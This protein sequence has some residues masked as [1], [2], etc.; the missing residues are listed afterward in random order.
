MTDLAEVYS[1]PRCNGIFR[2]RGMAA[3]SCPRCG[4]DP[5]GAEDHTTPVWVWQGGGR[6]S[7]APFAGAVERIELMAPIGWHLKADAELGAVLVG[8]M[9]R[10]VTA[11]EAVVGVVRVRGRT[12]WEGAP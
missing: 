3:T 11:A 4:P 12:A 8:P 6:C 5:D 9:G 10:E 1:C 7:F 2:V